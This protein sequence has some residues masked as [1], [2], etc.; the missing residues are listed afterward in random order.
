MSLNKIVFRKSFPEFGISHIIHN[1]QNDMIHSHL[2]RTYEIYYLV[3]G[4]RHYF[5]ENMFYSISAG[6]LVIIPPTILH[7]TSCESPENTAHERIL[8][9]LGESYISPVLKALELPAL[10]ALFPSPVILR[11]TP[12]AQKELLDI[13]S[14]IRAE[15]NVESTFRDAAIKTNLVR[16]LLLISLNG[17]GICH[18]TSSA[19]FHQSAKEQLAREAIIYIKNNF[20]DRITLS[21]LADN[22]HVSRGYISNVFNETIGMKIPDYVNLQ[23]IICAE[24]LLLHSDMGISQIAYE[25]G[26]DSSSYF[27]RIFKELEGMPPQQFRQERAHNTPRK[28]VEPIPS[29]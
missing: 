11:L 24:D 18:D 5:I 9:T 14:S 25:C 8:L 13:I 4:T 16:L 27:S 15:I 12:Q 1:T 19:A 26:F 2:H 10:S 20:R 28:A 21:S 17:S 23:R 3:E 7:R 6:M 29:S 22:L